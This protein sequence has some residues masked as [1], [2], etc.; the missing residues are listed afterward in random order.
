ML[1]MDRGVAGADLGGVLG[2]G[3]VA[4]MVQRLDA[5]VAADV[6]G[7]LGRA[8]LGRGEVGDRVYGHGAPGSV[9]Q[10]P[11]PAGDPDRLGGVGQADPGGGGHLV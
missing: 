11:D 4:D 2:V 10:R 5:P 8:G 1:A 9:A 7:R 6:I 3:G